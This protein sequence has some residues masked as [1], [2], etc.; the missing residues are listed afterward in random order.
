VNAKRLALM[1]DGAILINT[2]RGTLVDEPA[3]IA[4]LQRKRIWAFLDVTDPEPP[5]ADSPLYTCPNLTLTPHIA[6]SQKRG[7]TYLGRAAF[8][9]VQRFFAGEHLKGRVTKEMIDKIG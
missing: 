7:R 4:E 8:N 5:A 2:S 6:G 3:L 1:K 9:E